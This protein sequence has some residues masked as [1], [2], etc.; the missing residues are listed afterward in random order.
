MTSFIGYVMRN[1]DEWRLW[2]E[3][4]ALPINPDIPRS[5][6]QRPLIALALRSSRGSEAKAPTNPR[7]AELCVD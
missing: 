2:P 6:R 3:S 7:G 1:P 5:L 4:F